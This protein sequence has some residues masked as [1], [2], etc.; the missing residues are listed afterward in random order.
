MRESGAA[1]D[2]AEMRQG[3]GSKLKYAEAA[4]QRPVGLG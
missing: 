3:M 2:A 1:V 4:Q